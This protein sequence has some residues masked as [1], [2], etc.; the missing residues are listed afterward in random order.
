MP[1]VDSDHRFHSQSEF[2]SLDVPLAGEY[3]SHASIC[4]DAD[5]QVQHERE[6]GTEATAPC[7]QTG[8]Q[9][10]SPLSYIPGFDMAWDFGVDMMHVLEG[11]LKRNLIALLRGKRAPKRPRLAQDL[12]QHERDLIMEEYEDELERHKR[13]TLSKD[14]LAE[15]DRRSLA[16]GG[17]PAWIR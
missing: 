11:W 16:L 6:N 5:R 2:S 10:R 4:Q 8:V 12:S 15:L 9:A 7:K 14:A 17:E 13:W 3:R 1:C